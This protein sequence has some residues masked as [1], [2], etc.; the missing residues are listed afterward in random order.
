MEVP[1]IETILQNVPEWHKYS[2]ELQNRILEAMAL[3]RKD[4][5]RNLAV[6][7]MRTMFKSYVQGKTFDP[8]KVMIDKSE[9]GTSLYTYDHNGVVMSY[10]GHLYD[11]AV[12][13]TKKISVDGNQIYH[14]DGY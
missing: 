7:T 11:R 13:V 10:H 14:Y 5:A 8:D 1:S 12:V 2:L 4:K 6:E 9:K 3:Q